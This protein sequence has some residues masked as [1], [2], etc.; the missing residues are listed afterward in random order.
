VPYTCRPCVKTVAVYELPH[1]MAEK[2]FYKTNVIL[3]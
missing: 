3:A 1:R 2:V